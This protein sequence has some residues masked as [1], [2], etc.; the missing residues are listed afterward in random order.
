[1]VEK[2]LGEE[3]FETR[4]FLLVLGLQDGRSVGW[5]VE[6]LI[7]MNPSKMSS[8]RLDGR[9]GQNGLAMVDYYPGDI[10]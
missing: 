2:L 4:S 1:M 10:S 7:N 9:A 5:K 6:D 3:L 8:L